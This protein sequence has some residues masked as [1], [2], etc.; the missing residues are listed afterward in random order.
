MCVRAINLNDMTDDLRFRI[1]AELIGNDRTPKRV[2]FSAI[3]K[4]LGIGRQH[5]VYHVRRLVE[6]GYLRATS[7]GYEPTDRI[8]F[9]RGESPA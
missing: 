9:I 3:A 7:A 8:I 1:L 6:Q 2:D 5:V 4:R